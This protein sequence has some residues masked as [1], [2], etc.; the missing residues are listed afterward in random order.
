MV[1]DKLHDWT[2]DESTDL[3]IECWLIFNVYSIDMS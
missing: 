2:I 1:Y 3:S